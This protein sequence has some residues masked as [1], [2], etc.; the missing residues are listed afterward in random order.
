L[1][2]SGLPYRLRP[3]KHVDREL[4]SEFVACLISG[5]DPTKYV[6]ASMG[7]QHL[8]DHRSIY[9]R[10]GLKALYSFDAEGNV[11]GRQR[12]NRPFNSVVCEQHYSGE[13]PGKIDA[14]LS[15]FNAENLIVWLDY[16]DPLTRFAQLGEVESLSSR[17][18]AG[19]VLR[20]TFCADITRVEKLKSQLPKAERTAEEER[21]AVL[22]LHLGEY[23]PNS[24]QSV[25]PAEV[26]GAFS[27]CVK[28]AI[29]KGLAAGS[30]KLVPLPVLNTSY[31]DSTAMCV[32]T[33]LFQDKDQTV[34]V[35]T[36]WGYAPAGWA[37]FML[38]DIPDITPSEKAIFD[39]LMH[40]DLEVLHE[41]LGFR[42][43][44]SDER[45]KVLLTN[46][47]KFHRYYPTFESIAS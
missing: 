12:F 41:T 40:Q 13:L 10:S 20:V 5:R 7:G 3:R 29:E 26:P 33:V 35:P 14:I 11:V 36:G 32:V 25:L 21:A 28:R 24:I 45:A 31:I 43:D 2:G 19:D 23:F 47:R 1:S 9:R 8:A 6:Y 4:F 39:Q 38:I 46:Y 16:T 27:M 18:D 42:L 44:D 17:F 37:D 30:R 15:R 34:K 22:K